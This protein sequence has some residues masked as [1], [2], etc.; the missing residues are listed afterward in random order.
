MLRTLEIIKKTLTVGGRGWLQGI[1]ND[2]T[3][4]WI[5]PKNLA[6]KLKKDPD[7]D[8]CKCIRLYS[9]STG[10]G[11]NSFAE[12]LAKETG[13]PVEAPDEVAWFGPTGKG[14]VAPPK[15]PSDPISKWKPDLT[16]KGSYKRFD[17]KGGSKKIPFPKAKGFFSRL[18]GR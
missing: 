5:T 17:P 1:K 18:F 2:Q 12:Q 4:E 9:C 13:K 11:E 7:F 10:K 8:K 15:N 3:G 14:Y 16:N 6:D